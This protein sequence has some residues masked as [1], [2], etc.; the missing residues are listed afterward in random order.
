MIN[1]Q[2]TNFLEGVV[3]AVE[4]SNYERLMLWN[5]NRVHGLRIW[6]HGNVVGLMETV[7]FVDSMPVCISLLVEVIDGH[8]IL[9]WEP[10]SMVVD[11]RLIDDWFTKTMPKSAYREGSE[12]INKTDAMNFSNLFHNRKKA[13]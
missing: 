9:F 5:E 4:A 11:H 1:E 7:G 3:G 6:N 12:Y 2:M 13:A 10:T 8:K